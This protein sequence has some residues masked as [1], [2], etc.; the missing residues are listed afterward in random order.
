[1]RTRK[2]IENEGDNIVGFSCSSNNLILETL[3][4]IRDQNEEI[5]NQLIAMN[6]ITSIYNQ[7]RF[8]NG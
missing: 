4:D 3:L 7:S 2:E 8:R 6:S 1:M 5:K